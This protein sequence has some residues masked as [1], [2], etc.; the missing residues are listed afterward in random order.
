GRRYAF[1]PE[2][3]RH[4]GPRHDRSE[5]TKWL[6]RLRDSRRLVVRHDDPGRWTALGGLQRHVTGRQRVV[7]DRRSDQAAVARAGPDLQHAD[8]RLRLGRLDIRVWPASSTYRR[9][10]AHRRWRLWQLL[11]ADAP[12]RG[13]GGWR[14]HAYRHAPPRVDVRD[15]R[16]HAVG[17]RVRS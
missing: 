1:V 6:T 10:A 8:H 13:A 3:G 15:G 4:R 5:D 7:G 2:E 14:R 12:A 11:A 9:S 17:D 16:L